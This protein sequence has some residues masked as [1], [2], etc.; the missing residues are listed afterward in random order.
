[1]LV[2][3]LKLIST[4]S[5]VYRFPPYVAHETEKIRENLTAR[6]NCVNKW[7]RANLCEQS[8]QCFN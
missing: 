1:M 7:N 8:S 3:V 6:M 5:A 4:I 2:I